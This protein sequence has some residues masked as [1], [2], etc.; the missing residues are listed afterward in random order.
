MY[1]DGNRT[2]PQFGDHAYLRLAPHSQPGYHTQD[3]TKL[4]GNRL[5]PLQIVRAV[6][7][8]AYEIELPPWLTS[9]HLVI[10]VEHLELV[11][12]DPFLYKPVLTPGPL[13]VDYKNGEA[14]EKFIIE[15]IIAK[16]RRK[17]AGARDRII[18]YQ[19]KWFNYNALTWEPADTLQVDVPD[20]VKA[21]K[22]R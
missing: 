10:S 6:G 15:R 4:L 8:L 13:R 14:V 1:Y 7:K 17:T 22:R 21:F 12:L 19:V 3:Q 9:V 20:L 5:G 18:K 16:R 2:P 11:L